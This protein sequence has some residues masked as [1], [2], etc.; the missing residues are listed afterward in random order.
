MCPGYP[1]ILLIPVPRISV[2]E[3]LVL[4]VSIPKVIL[5]LPILPA[6]LGVEISA[7]EHLIR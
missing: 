5:V 4:E 2:P 1:L 3:M 6:Y 7:P